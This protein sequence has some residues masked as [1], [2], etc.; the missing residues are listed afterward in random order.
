MNII[1]TPFPWAALAVIAAALVF[2]DRWPHVAVLLTAATAL[3]CGMG[4]Q[5]ALQPEARK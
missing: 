2:A 1:R 4:I 3:V 5:R